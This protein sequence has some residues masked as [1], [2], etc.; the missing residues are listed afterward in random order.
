MST[1]TTLLPY[2]LEPPTLA[3]PSLEP[4]HVS[5]PWKTVQTCRTRARGRPS[6]TT[7]RSKNTIIDPYPLN[8][9]RGLASSSHAQWQ[10]THQIESVMGQKLNSA[11]QPTGFY[12]GDVASHG[13]NFHLLQPREEEREH[14]H[15]PGEDGCPS[16][17][18]QLSDVVVDNI[19]TP[20]MASCLD[21]H[22]HSP[23][24]YAMQQVHDILTAPQSD[25]IPLDTNQNNGSLI[26]P[27]LIHTHADEPRPETHTNASKQP[28]FL[29]H[30]HHEQPLTYLPSLRAGDG[31]SRTTLER[32]VSRTHFQ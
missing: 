18:L 25:P 7:P 31:E 5:T 16:L 14:M 19:S 6:E 17:P 1:P 8:Q 10:C 22:Q 11:K 30:S 23:H 12:C 3:D 32:T 29:G 28:T 13:K 4:T 24:A 20:C 27:S 26:G 21:E 2:E 9:P 15:E